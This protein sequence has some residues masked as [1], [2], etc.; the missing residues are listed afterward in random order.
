MSEIKIIV[1]KENITFKFCDDTISLLPLIVL[2]SSDGKETVQSV[3]TDISSGVGL[4]KIFLFESTNREF[5]NNKKQAL[6]VFFSY[7]MQQ[8]QKKRSFIHQFIRP[9]VKVSGM[10]ELNELL[11]GYQYYLIED[12]LLYAGARKIIFID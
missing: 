5:C 12:S 9:I 1:N 7:G 4:K 11:L 3:G 10:E 8:I 6:E 2:E